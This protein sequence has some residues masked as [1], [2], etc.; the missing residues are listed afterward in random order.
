MIA[1]HSART[2]IQFTRRLSGLLLVLCIMALLVA[3]SRLLA[4][5]E[6]AETG[7]V[8]I[9][10]G[11][12]AG[13]GDIDIYR[14]PDMEAGDL[15]TVYARATD[16]NLDPFLGFLRDSGDLER[17]AQDYNVSVGRIVAANE[18]LTLA[19]NSLR[20][21]FFLDWDDDSGDGYA[22]TF[23]YEIPS[24]GDYLLMVGSALGA[25]N[26]YTFGTYELIVGRNVPA[27][28]P[29]NAQPSGEPFAFFD[30]AALGFN[31]AVEEV[32]GR[33]TGQIPIASYTLEPIEAESTIYA[34]VEATSP[35]LRP[36]LILRDFG[37]K[38]LAAGNVAGSDS[39]ASLQ[40]PLPEGAVNYTLEVGPASEFTGET[41]EQTFRL[42]VGL[43]APEVL[44]DSASPTGSAVLE[45]PTPVQVGVRLNRISGVNSKEE[46][47]TMLGSIRMD[48][49]NPAY[50]FSPDTCNCNVKVYTGE[51]FRNFLTEIES[52]WP[53]FAFFNQLGQRFPRSRAAAIWP[54]G[55]A[56]YVE[57]FTATFQADFD[58]R[59]FP[60]D[61]ETFPVYIDM[62]FATDSYVLEEL[63]GY[64]AISS[65]HGED[66]FM[67]TDFETFVTTET[68]IIGSDVS[69]F[70]FQF[71][72][73]RHLDYYIFQIFVPILLIALIS[74]FTFFLRDYTR[75][76]EA[77][78][79]NV[80]LFIAF[81][82]SLADNYPRLGY[83][84]F[85]DAIMLVTFIINTAVVLY[86]VYLKQLESNGRV[87][88]ADEID[89]YLDWV[90]PLSYLALVGLVVWV[91]FGR[92]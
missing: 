89:R 39:V 27:L 52:R 10:S 4:G 21:Q 92:G 28:S 79:A 50:A 45:A 19:I 80:L 37:G 2:A 77:A 44:N 30:P 26:R 68:G 72:A 35:E 64:S 91:F 5:Q 23:T 6:A 84:T 70:T 75:R 33:L 69:R 22:A 51:D 54:D 9:F 38:P 24:S 73:P 34:Y 3:P 25:L 81:S 83:L 13:T 61:R 20:D 15:I 1:N 78:A 18:D 47:F 40:L 65:D 36:I 16:G 57:D 82:F 42:V 87:E 7:E 60:F 29:D 46:S 48:W 85:L 14:L 11:L 63:P 88:R 12:M 58:F 86:N 43:N 74:W 76:I 62:L 31:A 32:T 41:N 55:R 59:Q 56:T 8:Q 17:V 49:Q 67:I 90:Y 53:E 66:E 71:T